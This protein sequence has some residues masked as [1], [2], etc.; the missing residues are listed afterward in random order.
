MLIETYVDLIFCSAVRAHNYV[1][2]RGAI[3][4]SCSGG[5]VFVGVSFGMDQ[6]DG[7]N[8]GSSIQQQ[9]GASSVQRVFC[10]SFFIFWKFVM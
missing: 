1:L 4:G 7:R 6:L 8:P 5:S 9:S 3:A 2:R 10:S